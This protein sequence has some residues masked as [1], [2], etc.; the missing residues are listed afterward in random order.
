MRWIAT[1]GKC[2]TIL[3]YNKMHGEKFKELWNLISLFFKKIVWT[4][5]WFI[6]DTYCVIRI[7]LYEVYKLK[8]LKTQF[9]KI[10]KFETTD[11][12]THKAFASKL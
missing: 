4:Q 9:R 7:R 10:S 2:G 11:S 8:Y 1:N 3:M 12:Q 5:Y 6:Q